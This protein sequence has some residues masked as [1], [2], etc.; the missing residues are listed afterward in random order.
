M[1]EWNP[2]QDMMA[3]FLVDGDNKTF[4]ASLN[5]DE[6]KQLSDAIQHNFGVRD[7]LGRWDR[8]NQLR[9]DLPE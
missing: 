2:T 7:A 3:V 6:Q 8:M 5:C 9:R 1:F 4:V